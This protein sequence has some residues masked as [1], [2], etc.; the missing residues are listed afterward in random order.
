MSWQRAPLYVRAHDLA[1][2]LMERAAGWRNPPE[3][4]LGRALNAQGLELSSSISL[5]LTFP[6][7]RADHQERADESVV[8]IR[9]ILRLARDL[10]VLSPRQLRYAG[11]ELDAIGR[12]L[13][14]WRRST[15]ARARVRRERS[16]VRTGDGAQAAPSA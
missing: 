2:W 14:G 10:G 15:R 11:A 1:R 6:A 5:A 12:M 16:N 4:D 3:R 8:R 7:T 13:G 9:S